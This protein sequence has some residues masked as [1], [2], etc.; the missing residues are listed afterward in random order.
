MKIICPVCKAA[1]TWEENP[2]RPFCS[3]RCKLIDLGKWASGEYRVEGEEQ[4]ES[5]EEGEGANE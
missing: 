4:E 1:T 2:A 3:D 5:A